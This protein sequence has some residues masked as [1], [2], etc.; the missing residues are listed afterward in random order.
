M[1]GEYRVPI[2]KVDIMAMRNKIKVGDR[3]VFYRLSQEINQW[4]RPI[5]TV[6]TIVEKYTH[7]FLVKW[8]GAGCKPIN[9]SITY[10]EA[11]INER[12]ENDRMKDKE[13][14]WKDD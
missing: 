1:N 6:G 3:Y 14:E 2:K 8:Y 7:H 13:K 5:R 9:T 12:G 11:I 4:G 10:I